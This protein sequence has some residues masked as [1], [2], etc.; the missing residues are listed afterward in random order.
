MAEPFD[1]LKN[2]VKE[3]IGSPKYLEE[4]TEPQGNEKEIEIPVPGKRMLEDSEIND[5]TL[6]SAKPQQI[7]KAHVSAPK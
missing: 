7:A 3:Q 5:E 2:D 1:I 6:G 4:K